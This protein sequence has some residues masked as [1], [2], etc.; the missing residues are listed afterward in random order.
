MSE[1]GL[2]D[3]FEGRKPNK[4]TLIT[5]SRQSNNQGRSILYKAS[6]YTSNK[7][8]KQSSNSKIKLSLQIEENKDDINQREKNAFKGIQIGSPVAQ[9]F[10]NMAMKLYPP[11]DESI[12][13]L[14]QKNSEDLQVKKAN[15]AKRISSFEE[16][17]IGESLP[18]PN[19]QR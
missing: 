5:P 13:Y 10:C 9:E 7:N 16:K 4:K 18:M 2:S 17:S 6:K 19:N 11:P 1:K 12:T 15:S 8:S 14:R 3:K